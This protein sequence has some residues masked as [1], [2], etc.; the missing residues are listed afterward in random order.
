MWGKVS[1]VFSVSPQSRNRLPCWNPKLFS[2]PVSE[3]EVWAE[4]W[5]L[6][7]ISCNIALREKGEN[8]GF[9]SPRNM[10][11]GHSFTATL[12]EVAFLVQNH[13]VS[14]FSWC[15]CFLGKLHIGHG[16]VMASQRSTFHFINGGTEPFDFMA[17]C[18]SPTSRSSPCF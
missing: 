14:W 13:L 11:A 9:S 4:S 12:R 1:S 10:D 15:G 3:L 6:T 18:T 5:L 17:T 2:T 16:S 8:V 7:L